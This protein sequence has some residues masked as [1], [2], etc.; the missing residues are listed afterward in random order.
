MVISC[1]GLDCDTCEA[2]LATK[3]NDD[4]LR[5]RTAEKWTKLYNH[6]LK[7][8]DINCTDCQNEGVKVGHCMVCKIRKCCIERNLEHC[9]K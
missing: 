3:N 4:S 2:Y 5:Q 1:C 7:P 6:P 8:E 9:E